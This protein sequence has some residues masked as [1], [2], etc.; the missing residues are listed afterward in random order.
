[1]FFLMGSSLILGNSNNSKENVETKE[2]DKTVA[3]K[4][5]GKGQTI[6][7]GSGLPWGS[8]RL[9]ALPLTEGGFSSLLGLSRWPPLPPFCH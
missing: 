9:L 4:M 1:M 7:N 5:R 2:S 8:T 3:S 6:R